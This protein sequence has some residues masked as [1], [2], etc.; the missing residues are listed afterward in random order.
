M[1]T[2]NTSASEASKANGEA[3]DMA[4]A[5]A[6]EDDFDAAVAPMQPDPHGRVAY[7]EIEGAM[8]IGDDGT[9]LEPVEEDFD[10]RKPNKKR[11]EFIRCHPDRS[12]WQQA[13]VLVDEDGFDRTVYLVVKS[14][15]AVLQDF[16]S[17]VLLVPCLNQDGTFFLWPIAISD[18]ALGR[19]NS[20]IE[21]SARQIAERATHDWICPAFRS[22]QYYG[23]PARGTAFGAPEWPEGLTRRMINERTFRDRIIT[24]TTHEIAQ[25]HLGMARR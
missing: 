2:T 9:V 25:I 24:N 6:M 16:L 20:K 23:I 4:P 17:P 3:A 7:E 12:L 13:Y 22:G 1:T 11:A 19:R 21:R 14:M 18:I 5:P 10:C 8:G 15:Q